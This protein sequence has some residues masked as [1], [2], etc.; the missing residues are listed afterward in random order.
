MSYQ[1]ILVI[2]QDQVKSESIRLYIM[3]HVSLSYY[4]GKF[5]VGKVSSLIVD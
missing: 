1:D 4:V 3:S 5:Q 2:Y